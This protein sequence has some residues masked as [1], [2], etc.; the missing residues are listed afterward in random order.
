MA[1]LLQLL[2]LTIRQWVLHHS[3]PPRSPH[4]QTVKSSMTW[5]WLQLM[6]GM[7]WDTKCTYCAFAVIFHI[8]CIFWLAMLCLYS[9]EVCNVCLSFAVCRLNLAQF[10][11]TWEATNT[12][13]FLIAGMIVWM[14]QCLSYLINVVC[15][16]TPYIPCTD[17]IVIVQHMHCLCTFHCCRRNTLDTTS[18]MLQLGHGRHDQF[19][20]CSPHVYWAFL[21]F[22]VT[23]V[24]CSIELNT[25][26]CCTPVL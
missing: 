7:M 2:F 13:P 26:G 1:K 21:W 23:M 3:V 14:L 24:C 5:C 8:D 12:W 17:S 6:C 19:V 4:A 9:N 15:M 22:L 16:F 25:A 10:C 11:G 20:D 18:K